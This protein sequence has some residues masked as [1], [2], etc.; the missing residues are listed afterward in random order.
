MTESTTPTTTRAM[1]NP[2]TPTPR[3]AS[4]FSICKA[5]FGPFFMFGFGVGWDKSV[6]D[7]AFMLIIGKHMLMIGPH[8]PI[9]KTVEP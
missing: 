7:A 1:S 5:N 2:L 3:K 8:Y 4:L 9:S 6:P